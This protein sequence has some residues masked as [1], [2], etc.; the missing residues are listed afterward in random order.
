MYLFPN[1]IG[2][3]SELTFPSNTL[4]WGIGIDR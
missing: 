2:S 3:D 1:K 4:I